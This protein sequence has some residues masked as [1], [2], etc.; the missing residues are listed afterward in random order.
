MTNP[1]VEK[2]VDNLC[3]NPPGLFLGSGLSVDQLYD[4]ARMI[5]EAELEFLAG[6]LFCYG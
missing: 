4:I 5:R 6:M 2:I 3:T 1:A